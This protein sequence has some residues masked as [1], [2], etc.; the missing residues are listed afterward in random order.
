MRHRI[1]AGVL[2]EDEGRILLVRYFKEGE[3]DYW[4]APGGGAQD[5]EDLREAARR[6]VLEET[7]LH[8]EVGNIAY[9]EDLANAEV[10]FLKVW[11]VGRLLGGTIDVSG[12]DA[13]SEQIVEAAFLSPSEFTGKIVFPPMLRREYWEDKQG[14][15]AFPRYVG[16]RD[17]TF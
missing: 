15:F 9:V 17:M 7:G 16:L 6:E 11:F 8:V 14:G 5:G 2:V 10:R 13:I 12:P 1:S 4:V 3:F